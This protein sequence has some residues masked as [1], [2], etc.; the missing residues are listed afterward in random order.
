MRNLDI[1][2][3]KIDEFAGQ[4]VAIDPQREIILAAGDTLDEISDLVVHPTSENREPEKSPT[5]FLVPRKDEGPYV[6]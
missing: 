3:D 6:L 2:T 5:A 1:S 4:W